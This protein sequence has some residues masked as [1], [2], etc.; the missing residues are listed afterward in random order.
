MLVLG[1]DTYSEE[2]KQA[3]LL[4]GLE[5]LLNSCSVFY[6]STFQILINAAE[7]TLLRTLFTTKGSSPHDIFILYLYE[8]IF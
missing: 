5:P 7:D 8:P 4:S 2:R 3:R 6:S 1:M